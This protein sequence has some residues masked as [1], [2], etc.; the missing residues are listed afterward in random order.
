[1]RHSPTTE[2]TTKQIRDKKINR[3]RVSDPITTHKNP[4]LNKTIACV[5]MLSSEHRAATVL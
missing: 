1:M 4:G 5:L 3:Y 2:I